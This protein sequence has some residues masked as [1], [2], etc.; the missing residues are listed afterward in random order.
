MTSEMLSADKYLSVINDRGVRRLPLKRVYRNMRREGLFLKAYAKL[1]QNSGAGT[2]GSD[3]EDTIQG[4][5]VKRIQTIIQS[6]KDGQYQWKPA[7]RVYVPK[8]DGSQRPISIPG[9]SDKLVQE[10][11]RSILEAYYEPRFRKCSH[12]FRPNRSC[13]TALTKIKETWKGTK[14]FIEGDIKGCFDNIDHDVLLEILARDIQDNRFLKLIKGMLKAGY[15]EDWKYQETYSGAPQGGVISPLLANTVLH[16]LDCYVEDVLIPQHTQGKQ[17]KQNPEYKR[18]ADK[19]YRAKAKG[20]WETYQEMGKR[21][22][23]L[24]FGDPYDPEFRRLRYIR[25]ADDFI[26][27]FI[28]P[29]REAETIKQQLADFLES[30]KLK[31]SMRKTT[32]R[33]SRSEPARFLGYE[34]QTSSENTKMTKRTDGYKAR[35]VTGHVQLRVPK[36]V[37][38]KWVSKY[39][40]GGKPTHQTHLLHLSDYEIVSN[41]GAQLRGIVNYYLM[42]INVSKRLDKVRW[43]GMEACRLTLKR[44]HRLTIKQSYARYLHRPGNDSELRHIRVVIARE[45]KSPLIAKCGET[46]LRVRKT[47]YTRDEIPP[48]NVHRSNGSELI[49]RLTNNQCELCER[50]GDV[51]VHH[52]NKLSN[53]RRSWAGRK[54]KPDWVRFMLARRRKTIIVCPEC[55]QKITFGKYDGKRVR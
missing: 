22:R 40:K 4:M 27:G 15:L 1:Y 32:I 37:E 21:M 25:Y 24:P 48:S 34:L 11:M 41:M 43:Y 38:T 6:L 16:E 53:I 35:F 39:T 36:D 20:D 14:W 13:H 45:G 44:K 51:E 26:L 47:K 8:A 29:K 5:S 2:A 18:W 31:L 49:E 46:P 3:R 55:H 19:R 10:V 28:G 7:R 42:A 12:G 50:H 30:I 54:Q 9:W 23:Q 33:H 52:V 17:R